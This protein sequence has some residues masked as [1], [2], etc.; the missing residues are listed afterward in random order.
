MSGCD[1]YRALGDFVKRHR[2][3][4]I[5]TF[6][7]QKHGVPSYSTIRR[8]VMGVDFEKFASIFNSWAKQYVNLD[9]LEWCGIDVM[10]KSLKRL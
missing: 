6:N 8:V 4:L 7:I 10:P 1:G 3:T 5:E 2:R 9:E